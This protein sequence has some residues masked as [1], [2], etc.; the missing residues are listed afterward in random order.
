MTPPKT[1]GASAIDGDKAAQL[2]KLLEALGMS[3]PLSPQ[4]AAPK[5]HQ[6]WSTQPVP[7]SAS[8]LVAVKEDG[9]IHKEVPAISTEPY[10]LP[11][12]F[13]WC[14]VGIDDEKER[15]ELY[16]LLNQNYVEDVDSQFRFDYPPSFLEWYH[17]FVHHSHF[18]TV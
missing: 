15:A 6:F 7:K 10:K 9:P 8:E 18:L 5:E 2:M 17:P 1:S 14:T 13:K 4:P 11:E 3:P 12:S 16:Q